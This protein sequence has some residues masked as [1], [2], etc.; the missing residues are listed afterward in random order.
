MSGV[1]VI[2]VYGH[3][4]YA[5]VAVA[6]ALSTTPDDVV[7]YVVDD[8]GPRPDAQTLRRWRRTPRVQ[9]HRMS[10]N[11][12]LTAV[13][14]L[15]LRRHRHADVVVLGNSDLKFAPGWWAPL[16]ESS[17]FFSL[18]GPVTSAPGHIPGQ[19]VSKWLPDYVPDDSDASL[20]ETASRLRHLGTRK[21]RKVNGFCMAAR[22]AEWWAMAVSPL[23]VFKPSLRMQGQEDELQARCRNA[24]KR[25]AVVPASFVFHYRSVTR[26]VK[27][28][29]D[30]TFRLRVP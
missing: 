17:K 13:W 14:N 15:A 21:I 9:Y 22:P 6:S 4:E 2:P 29:R 3:F 19:A 26:G 30:Q 18:V 10:A 27:Y 7:I 12:G 24:G 5:A 20:A 28:G 16:V 8:A 25:I 23:N 11:V 1:V